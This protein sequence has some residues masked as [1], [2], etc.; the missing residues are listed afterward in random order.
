MAAAGPL[1]LPGGGPLQAAVAVHISTGSDGMERLDS[2]GGG[3]LILR[4]GVV[5]F[6]YGR[7]RRAC[8]L[9]MGSSGPVC[10]SPWWQGVAALG[11]C[12]LL[13]P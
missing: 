6:C 13:A 11:S 4:S 5:P 10:L 12:V 9:A 8:S 2:N 7:R 1:S 3:G